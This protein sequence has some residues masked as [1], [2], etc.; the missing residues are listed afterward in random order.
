MPT[1][2]RHIERTRVLSKA[3]K[4][5]EE[6]MLLLCARHILCFRVEELT[7]HSLSIPF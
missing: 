6:C 3:A 7:K 2:G 5:K 4:N 1:W